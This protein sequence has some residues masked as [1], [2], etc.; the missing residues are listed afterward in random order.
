MK[1]TSYNRFFAMVM[2]MLLVFGNG[3]LALAATTVTASKI[4]LSANELSLAIEDTQALT[5]TAVYSDSTSGDVTVN[6]DWSSDKPSVASVYNGIVTAKAEGTATIVAVYTYSDGTKFSQAATVTVTKKVKALTQNVQSLDLRKGETGSVILTATFSDN[7]TDATVADKAVW[8]TS[9]AAVATVVNGTVKG[10]SSGTA[11]ITGVYGKKTVT[12]TVNVEVAKRIAV[13]QPELALLLND[14]SPVVLTA[15]FADGTQENVTSLA[16][17][18]SSDEEV[19]DVLKG[20]ITGYKQGT[21]VITAKYGTKT[22]TVQVTVDQ[23]SKLTVDDQSVFLKPEEAQQLK[24]TAVYPDGTAKDVTSTAIWSSSDSGIAYVYKGKVYGYTAGTATVTG[25]YGDKSAV[26]DV[27]VAVA[28]YLDLSDESLSLK[29]SSTRAL[30]L[31]ATYAD[32]STEDVT[33]QAVWSSSNELVAYV[34]KGAVTTYKLAGTATLSAAY[35][36]LETA[37]EVEVGAVNKLVA[38]E[39][40]VFLQPEDT[41]Q[42]TLTAVAGDGSSSDVTSSAAWTTSDKSVALVSKGLITGYSVGT[43][44][45]TGTYNGVAATVTV[46]VGTARHL[47]LSATSLNLAVNASKTLALT[48]TFA[49]GA[50]A[51]VTGKAVWSSS[52]E[53]VAF[54]AKGIITAY[55]EG[56]VTITASYGSKTVT[57]T[58]AVGKSNKLSVDDDTVFLR[59]NKTQQLVLTALDADGAS[60]VVTDDAVWSTADENTATVTKGLI[61][62]YKTGAT[63]VTAVYGG[64]TVTITVNVETASRLNLTISKLN[65]GLDQSKA[66][67]VMASY[68]DGTSQDVT[69]DAVWSSDHADVADVSS[70]TITAYATGSAVI[71]ASY[72]GKSAAIT[73]TAG[74]PNKLTLQ[75]KTVELQEDET[76]QVT[77]TGQYSDG[78]DKTLTDEVEWSTSD[79]KIASVE[80]GLITGVDAGTA[81]ITAKAGTVT[82]TIT[83][84]VGLVDELAANASL[85]TM[86]AADK[87]QI[88]LTATDSAGVETDVTADADWTTSKATVATVKKGLVTG[89]LKGKATIT[90]SYGGQQTSI[91]IE[92]DQVSKIE[93]SAISLAM[94]S[95]GTSKVTVTIT[96]SD[97]KTKDVTDKAEWKSGSYKI[98]TVTKGTVKAVAYGKSYVSAAYGGKTVKVPVTVDVLK[99]LEISQMNLTLTAGQSVQLTATAT[100][101]DGSEADV[102]KSA[103]WSSSKELVATGKNGLIKANSKGSANISVKYGGKT[104]K[105]KVTVK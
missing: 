99:Y 76:Y 55:A 17:W 89:V 59:L 3:G 88:T 34:K 46:D 68:G 83:V 53:A 26:V 36:T 51:D 74:T 57:L 4:V 96:Y 13:D 62:G 16:V 86:A 98:V 41:K 61:T 19:A 2:S 67:T 1:K 65:L 95:G 25:T 40:S 84:N 14:S 104:V 90:A 11:V 9:D 43:A 56:T 100:F 82:A 29:T 69:E 37:L 64:K 77:A 45:I 58:T 60:S 97:G 70:G 15:V 20:V 103:V 94:K 44:T 92:V 72:G 66:V 24:L 79:A 31:T 102:S 49:D 101:E 32:G 87:E 80:D 6:S 81:V 5:A 10:V 8:S 63:T 85:I 47:A 78:S 91:N 54:V 21:A 22:T 50:T 23:T 33:S 27:D 93:A 35:G 52:D 73:V 75:A 28:R 7:A 48:A 38:S 42:L 105:I 12:V 71:T 30:T 39:E 18:S